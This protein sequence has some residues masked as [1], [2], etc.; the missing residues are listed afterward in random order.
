MLNLEF[1]TDEVMN[2]INKVVEFKEIQKAEKTFFNENGK[3]MHH[4]FAKY[5]I[6]TYHIKHLEYQ[7]YVYRD[8]IYVNDEKFIHKLMIKEIDNIEK[9]QRMETIEYIR[10]SAEQAELESPMFIAVKNGILNAKTGEVRSFSPDYFLTN[11]INAAYDPNA[12]NTDVENIISA[13][14]GKDDE[15]IT[16]LKEI[17]GY[18]IYR[19]NFLDKSFLFYGP[20]GTGKS[21]V[22]EMYRNFVGNENTSTVSLQGLEDKFNTARLLNK[23]LNAGDDIPKDAIKDSSNFKKLSTGESLDVQRKGQDPFTMRPFAKLMFASN[24]LPHMSD[25]VEAITDRFYIVPLTVRFRNTDNVDPHIGEKLNTENARSHMLNIAIEHLPKLLQ[26]NYMTTPQ[27][28]R[29]MAE[30]FVSENNPL[31]EF[32]KENDVHEVMTEEAHRLYQ[33]WCKDA[34]YFP[35]ARNRFTSAMK[36]LGYTVGDKRHSVNGRMTGNKKTFLKSE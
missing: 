29:D 5:L 3:F 1:T 16:L 23:L 30:R 15:V 21:K 2:R 14:A 34:G 6:K 9:S 36:D 7:L 35:L 19:E 22:I 8:G 11:K 27:V 33:D 4:N 10:Y 13:I 24:H 32:V 31:M 20:P 26:R 25:K 18:I 12:H 28:V 17:F